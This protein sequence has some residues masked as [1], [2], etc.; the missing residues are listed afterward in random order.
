MVPVVAMRAA[1]ILRL[2]DHPGADRI[3][4]Q[5]IDED[6]CTG[7][8]VGLV[9]VVCERLGEAQADLTYL[10]HRQLR[11]RAA[12]QRVHVHAIPQ[13]GDFADD[14]PRRLLERVGLPRRERLLR[15]PDHHR[16]D[17]RR[18]MRLL[19]GTHQHVAAADVD[20]IRQSHRHRHRRKSFL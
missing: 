13:L 11:R 8:R 15:H 2:E 10:V 17:L 20:F 5:T 12:L 1:A 4:R 14:L 19:I 7:R 16:L 6:E 9:R 18:N 3:V